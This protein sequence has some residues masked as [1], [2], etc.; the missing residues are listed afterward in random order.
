M[1]D[2]LILTRDI[3]MK[4]KIYLIVCNSFIPFELY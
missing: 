3:K 1:R 4:P 2:S